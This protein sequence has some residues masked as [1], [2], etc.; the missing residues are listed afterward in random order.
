MP[1]GRA[2][3]TTLTRKGGRTA[4]W[5]S[6][7]RC[8]CL[9]LLTLQHAPVTVTITACAL[10][11]CSV[12]RACGSVIRSLTYAAHACH[13][14]RRSRHVSNVADVGLG[15]GPAPALQAVGRISRSGSLPRFRHAALK[16]GAYIQAV[17]RLAHAM[18]PAHGLYRILR[19]Q[20]AAAERDRAH[21]TELPRAGADRCL[22]REGGV[23]QQGNGSCHAPHDGSCIVG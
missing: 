2:I 21:F 6:K 5:S 17:H 1:C 4:W 18:V 14:C 8:S 13:C 19:A 20:S 16:Q 23:G 10:Q 22:D 12:R 9:R 11:R 7:K 3:G 15:Q